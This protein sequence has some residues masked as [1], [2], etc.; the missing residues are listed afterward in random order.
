MPS[1]K[2]NRNRR[3]RLLTMYPG[4]IWCGIQFQGVHEHCT[5]EHLVPTALGGSNDD[6]NLALACHR[7]NTA[8]GAWYS[9]YAAVTIAKVKLL[10]AQRRQRD[11]DIVNRIVSRAIGVP[12]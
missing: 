8:R 1:S 11:R 10:Q 6:D 2:A 3:T 4:C 9:R 5:I 12:T 7:C